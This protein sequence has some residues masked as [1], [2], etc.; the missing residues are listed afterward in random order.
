MNLSYFGHK[1][2]QRTDKE[3]SQNIDCKYHCPSQN[4]FGSKIA[5]LI[6]QRV[7]DAGFSI[8]LYVFLSDYG[9]IQIDQ[10]LTESLRPILSQYAFI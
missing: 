10:L 5:L 3:E 6:V 1:I 4:E 7:T 8:N 9:E 2:L